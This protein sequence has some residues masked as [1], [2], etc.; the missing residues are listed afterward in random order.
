[1]ENEILNAF[2]QNSDSESD[3]STAN[4]SISENEYHTADD[5]DDFLI[6]DEF[7][8]SVSSDGT[9]WILPKFYTFQNYKRR[10]IFYLLIL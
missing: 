1:M 9:V 10:P 5:I 3:Y 7:E 6:T 8:Y 2:V 4:E